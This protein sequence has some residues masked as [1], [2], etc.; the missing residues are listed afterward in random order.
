MHA[1]VLYAVQPDFL[2]VKT[3]AV[4]SWMVK[5]TDISAAL[6]HRRMLPADTFCSPWSNWQ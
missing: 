5:F 1:F 6:F 3:A 2:K 4:C